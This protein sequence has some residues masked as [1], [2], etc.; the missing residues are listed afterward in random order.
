MKTRVALG[1]D[2]R[3]FREALCSILAAEP[4]LE[5]VGQGSTGAEI[6]DMVAR[7]VPDVL[8]LDIALPD[9]NGIE[10][11]RKCSKRHPEVKILAVTGYADKV[12]VEE[13]LKA[14]AQGY[15]VKSAGSD[16]LLKA[17][18]AAEEGRKFL[19]TE[20]IQALVQ[21]L[22]LD[23]DTILPPLNV[24]A[25][26]EQEVLRLLAGG[27]RSI[28]IAKKLGISPATVD[29]HRRNI[30]RKLMVHTT[31]ELTRY[32]VREGLITT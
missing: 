13:M 31:A 7:T 30:K 17:I 19:S 11:A 8:L 3:L 27:M 2:H 4:D 29:V 26:R 1:D 28:Q 23:Q 5:V 20:A 15:V 22:N 32:A 6:L 10:L 16:V 24:L 21:R 18:R 9:M 14:G 12:F 25:P